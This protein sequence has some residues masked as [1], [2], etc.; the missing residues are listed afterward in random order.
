[1]GSEEKQNNR[2][3]FQRNLSGLSGWVVI[4]A[5][6]IASIV[7]VM[8]QGIAEDEVIW[9]EGKEVGAHP[10][11]EVRVIQMELQQA[12]LANDVGHIKTAVDTLSTA[13]INNKVVLDAIWL[14]VKGE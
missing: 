6:V 13:A 4:I 11:I 5:V 7:T 14:K 12:L 3:W 9:H 1:M 8:S 10:S 2:N